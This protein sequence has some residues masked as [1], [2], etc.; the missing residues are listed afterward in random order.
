MIAVNLAIPYALRVYALRKPVP[1]WASFLLYCLILVPANTAWAITWGLSRKPGIIFFF[2]F[3]YIMSN[4][5]Q[6]KRQ[7]RKMIKSDEV[8]NNAAAEDTL[9]RAIKLLS[10]GQSAEALKEFQSILLYYPKSN[11][12][13]IAKMYISEIENK[14]NEE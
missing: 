5:Y 14:A 2:A 9:Q 11:S 10:T 12:A 3:L 4:G 1:W 6:S 8:D 13:D 7:I